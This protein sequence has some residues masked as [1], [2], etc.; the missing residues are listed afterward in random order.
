MAT[1]DG[2][3]AKLQGLIDKANE[4]TGNTNTDLTTAIDALVAG[5]GAGG[6]G[7]PSWIEEVDFQTFSPAADTNEIQTFSLNLK[8]APQVILIFSDFEGRENTRDFASALGFYG[9]NGVIMQ[10]AT[11]PGYSAYTQASGAFIAVMWAPT[12]TNAIGV[13]EA[14]NQYFTFATPYYGG[15]YCFWRSGHTYSIVAFSVKET[16]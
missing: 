1:A 12:G 8:A 13:L 15:Q 2:V 5:F 11:W 7:L 10:S 16:N 9:L 6:D 3:K 4:A 14:T